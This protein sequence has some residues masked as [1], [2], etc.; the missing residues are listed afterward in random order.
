MVDH[1]QSKHNLVHR[2]LKDENVLVDKE[3]NIKLIDFGSADRIISTGQPSHFHG[4][5]A[6]SAP[7][8]ISKRANYDPVKAEIWSLGVILYTM[9]MR[10]VP[11][12]DAWSIVNRQV[13]L[14]FD[15]STV[16]AGVFDLLRRLLEKDP[17]KRITL[18]AIQSHPWLIE[19]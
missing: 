3:Y 8:I 6:F 10:R 12:S 11:F 5:L 7:E 17:I 14:P 15:D 9:V 16:K 18:S 4:T 19:P 2:D 13:K 1:L